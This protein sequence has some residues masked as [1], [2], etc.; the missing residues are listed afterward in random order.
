MNA[1]LPNPEAETVHIESLDKF[2]QILT[3]WHAE[4]C[5]VVQHL[6]DV[7]EGSEFQVCDEGGDNPTTITMNADLLA[8]FK[9]GIEMTMMQLGTL[10]FG[11][12]YTPEALPADAAG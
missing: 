5:A 2:V 1:V 11:V 12:E 7:P 9:F 6:L 10:P 4:K 8:G 3:S